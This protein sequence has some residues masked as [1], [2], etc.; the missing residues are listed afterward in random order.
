MKK[1]EIAKRCFQV[2]EIVFVRAIDSGFCCVLAT[3]SL[4]RRRSCLRSFP[5]RNRHHDMK[6]IEFHSCEH[7]R[8]TD[9]SSY[10]S[11]IDIAT[12]RGWR[13]SKSTKNESFITKF[14]NVGVPTFL[15][16]NLC[17]KKF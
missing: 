9:H 1:T 15:C 3:T 17:T 12:L 4:R 16:V 7:W 6:G 5:L 2:D 8:E 14:L 13:R 11:L 10:F